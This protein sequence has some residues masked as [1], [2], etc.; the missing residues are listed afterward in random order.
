MPREAY[1]WPYV[2]G[3]KEGAVIREGHIQMVCRNGG[4]CNFLRF[5]RAET[6]AEADDYRCTKTSTTDPSEIGFCD[7]APHFT[8]FRKDD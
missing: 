8:G 6:L 5:Y 2:M 1:Y 3:H 4:Y 7:G